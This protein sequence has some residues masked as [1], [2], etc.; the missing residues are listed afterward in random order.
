LFTC[1]WAAFRQAIEDINKNVK[2]VTSG[3][4]NVKFSH[5]IGGGHYISVTSGYKCVDFRQWY[6]PYDSKD[7]KP[8]PKGVALRLDEWANFYG[9]ID[10]INSTFPTLGLAQPCYYLEDHMINEGYF[11]CTECHPFL[12]VHKTA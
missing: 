3:D 2:A 4:E 10:S 6:Q 9:L 12:N 7:I 5:H 11:Q 8:T 1:R